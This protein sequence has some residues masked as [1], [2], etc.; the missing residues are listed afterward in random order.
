[1]TKTTSHVKIGPLKVYVPSA[2]LPHFWLSHDLAGLFGLEF[3]DAAE[4]RLRDALGSAL[5]EVETDHESDAV[6]IQAKNAKAIVQTIRTIIGLATGK[7][8]SASTV[9]EAQLARLLK[10]LESFAVPKSQSYGVGDIFALPLE[11]GGFAFGRV[12]GRQYRL[13]V[14]CGLF[15][16]CAET[17]TPPVEE[18]LRSRMVSVVQFFGD[19]LADGRW[20]VIAHRPLGVAGVFWGLHSWFRRQ[21][22]L[23]WGGSGAFEGLANAWFGRTPWNVE[24]GYEYMLRRGVRRPPSA[25]VMTR[26]ERYKYRIE[27]GLDEPDV[28]ESRG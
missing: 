10:K 18:I 24:V 28:P 25:R 23:V 4:E 14:N 20:V 13:Q 22:D 5:S 6:T 15:E 12:L 16:Y 2:V 7:S 8:S 21:Q 1:M 26:E 9:T 11:N 19:R 17:S 27:Q 3:N